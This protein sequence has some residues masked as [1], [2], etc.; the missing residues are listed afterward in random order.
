MNKLNLYAPQLVQKEV[1]LRQT[2]AKALSHQEHLNHFRCVNLSPSN[3]SP[4][5]VSAL[6]Q[7]K[8]QSSVASATLL[9]LILNS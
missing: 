3:K 6:S 4:D 8:I 1:R 7:I 2:A 5:S 9:N